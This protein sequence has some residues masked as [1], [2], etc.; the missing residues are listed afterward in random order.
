[1][2]SNILLIGHVPGPLPEG[3]E[4]MGSL[5]NASVRFAGLCGIEHKAL[6]QYFD[7]ENLLGS[8]AKNLKED[9]PFLVGM[10]RAKAR[11]MRVR[12]RTVVLIGH[13]VARAFNIA[14]DKPLTWL[15]RWEATMAWMP[16]PI[17]GSP[18]YEVPKNV[19]KAKV[20][21]RMLIPLPQS[22]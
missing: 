9:D 6:L 17:E 3:L 5:G 11:M 16:N 4:F 20:F 1:M 14:D 15:P 10:A 13:S 8:T 7:F 19:E 12:G 22:R 2:M 21:C 18:W